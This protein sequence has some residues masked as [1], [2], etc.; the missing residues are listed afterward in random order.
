MPPVHARRQRQAM[1]GGQSSAPQGRWN[2][3]VR[4]ERQQ[5]VPQQRGHKHRLQAAHSVTAW[6]PTRDVLPHGC[7]KRRGRG[8]CNRTA[9]SDHLA[10]GLPEPGGSSPGGSWGRSGHR[11]RSICEPCQQISG[12]VRAWPVA[13]IDGSGSLFPIPQYQVERV[14]LTAAS[15]AW[16]NDTEIILGDRGLRRILQR[17]PGCQ[18]GIERRTSPGSGRGTADR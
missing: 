16:D 18:C 9:I 17:R 6:F 8:C 1:H 10:P 7:F 13:T 14:C 5:V 3:W 4:S 15:V 11:L 2:G 12:N